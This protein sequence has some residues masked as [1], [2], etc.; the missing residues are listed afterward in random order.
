MNTTVPRVPVGE[1]DYDLPR[2]QIKKYAP[3]TLLAPG[4]FFG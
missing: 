4:S 2:I 1:E 3:L